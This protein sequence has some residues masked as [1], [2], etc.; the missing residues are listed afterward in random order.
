MEFKLY[1]G[2]FYGVIEVKVSIGVTVL[3]VQNEN[4]HMKGGI[5]GVFMAED[6]NVKLILDTRFSIKN[7]CYLY[8][9]NSYK[10]TIL[11][12]GRSIKVLL[13]AENSWLVKQ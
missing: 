2:T 1:V 11:Y 10:K 12:T 8:F 7:V 5:A 13:W 9:C 4:N 3:L 6:D